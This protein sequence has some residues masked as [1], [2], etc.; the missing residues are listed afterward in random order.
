[1]DL[2][3]DGLKD[4]LTASFNGAPQWIENTKDGYKEA[5][6]VLGKDGDIVML[7]KYWD[8]SLIHI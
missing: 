3:G 1:M 8:L 6:S 2:N 5:T 7:S 4:I